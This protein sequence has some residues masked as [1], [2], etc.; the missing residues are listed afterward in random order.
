MRGANVAS[1]GKGKR[2]ASKASNRTPRKSAKL[3]SS[4]WY[5]RAAVAM[6]I[7]RTEVQ[8]PSIAPE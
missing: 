3:S 2:K 8:S 5:Q 7:R 1:S 4:D 6:S